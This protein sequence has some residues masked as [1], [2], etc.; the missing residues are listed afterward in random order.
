MGA[1][2]V[3][4]KTR[5]RSFG[6]RI[7]ALWDANRD[8]AGN[9][10][11]DGTVA[12]A[13]FLSSIMIARELGP[14]GRG[15]ISAALLWP[16]TFSIF[17]MVGLSHAMAYAAGA[18]WASP[19]RLAR[20]GFAYSAVVGVPMA[21]VYFV[22]AP[23][24]LH[25]QF[26]PVPLWVRCFGLLIP[27]SLWFGLWWEVFRG[28]G[29]FVTWNV[30]KLLRS[31]G[32]TAWIAAALLVGAASVPVVLWSQFAIAMVSLTFLAFRL[33]GVT[34]T[35]ETEAVPVRRIMRYGAAV[36]VSSIFYMMNQQLDQLLLSLYASADALGQYATAVSLSGIIVAGSASVS[37]VAF[38]RMARAND[39]R[40]KSKAEITKALILGA[41]LVVPSGIGLTAFAPTLVRMVYG[42]LFAPAGQ[43]L[44]ILAPAAVLLGGGNVLSDLLRGFGKPLIPTY[45]MAFGVVVTVPSLIWLLPRYGMWAAAWVSLVA[46]AAM[47]GVQ[48]VGLMRAAG[49]WAG[50]DSEARDVS[51][52]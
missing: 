52:R 13:G 35:G 31:I 9:A 1:G 34:P 46:Y 45:A 28:V 23:L 14:E 21:F 12:I 49:V 51:C 15:Q 7:S 36:Y 20:F 38:S 17:G 6:E 19:R 48:G 18:G 27:L 4:P 37:A 41:L 50:K 5:A 22:L 16:G 29:D 2:D 3:T 30:V 39:D 10:L 11:S 42:P 43:V 40:F 44:R 25:K 26:S 8:Y 33:R 47:L 24:L 32:Y